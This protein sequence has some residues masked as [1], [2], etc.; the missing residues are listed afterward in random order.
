MLSPLQAACPRCANW[1]KEAPPAI[2]PSPPPVAAPQF[3]P[4]L[5]SPYVP[6]QPGPTGAFPPGMTD[7]QKKGVKGCTAV[8]VFLIVA[9]Y[10]F[11]LVAGPG[12]F[13]ASQDLVISNVTE[14]RENYID[15]IVGTVTNNSDRTYGYV[16]VEVNLYDGDVLIGSTM[17]NVNNLEP[18]GS[19]RF[20]AAS[21]ERSF[22]GY[23]VKGVTGF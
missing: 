16:Q 11:Y 7:G 22:T 23:K 18:H 3:N 12:S 13:A 5:P 8:G 2:A 9:L 14:Q 1:P 20:K 15:Y 6:I 4:I 21:F 17:A 19:W 10:A